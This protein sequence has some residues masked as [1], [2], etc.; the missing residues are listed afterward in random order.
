MIHV[1]PMAISIDQAISGKVDHLGFA[2]P[3]VTVRLE[4]GRI[5]EALASDTQMEQ[6]MRQKVKVRLQRTG[7]GTWKLIDQ[8]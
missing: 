5:V 4:N 7:E 1:P 6:A 8:D 2:A 3:T